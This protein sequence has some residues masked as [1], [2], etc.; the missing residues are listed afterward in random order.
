MAVTYQFVRK[1]ERTSAAVMVPGN[2]PRQDF[3][4]LQLALPKAMVP[5][6]EIAERRYEDRDPVVSGLR[7]V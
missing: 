5:D 7:P 3:E 1:N 6:A 2:W 4:E